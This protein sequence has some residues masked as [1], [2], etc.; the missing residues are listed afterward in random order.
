[1]SD[2]VG[3]ALSN[4][5]TAVARRADAGDLD[6]L[7]HRLAS[8][9]ALAAV[10]CKRRADGLPSVKASTRQ[11]ICRR[12]LAAQEAMEADIADAWTLKRMGAAA[13]MAPHHF[14]RS[15]A[16]YFGEPPRRFLT[17]RRLER[18]RALLAAGRNVTEACLDV[19]YESLS[20][21]SAAYRKRFGEPP[22]ARSRASRDATGA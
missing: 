21:F 1:M 15:F 5:A 18:A 2:C 19:G 13:A 16:Q 3:R 22:S 8:A 20:S 17:R 10:G 6:L 12:L 11:E 14:A 4:V 9:M 7:C